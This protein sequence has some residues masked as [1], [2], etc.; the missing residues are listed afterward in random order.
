VLDINLTSQ[1]VASAQQITYG[2]SS[3]QAKIADVVFH[4]LTGPGYIVADYLCGENDAILSGKAKLTDIGLGD[5]KLV[6]KSLKGSMLV[7]NDVLGSGS[8]TATLDSKLTKDVGEGDTIADVVGSIQDGLED[9]WGAPVL[10]TT[11]PD[12]N[13]MT[14]AVLPYA[15][16]E[17]S[18]SMTAH[19]VID[20]ESPPVKYLFTNVTD[21]NKSSLWQDSATFTN[22]GLAEN[23]T[24][25]YNVQACDSATPTQNFTTIS[26][27]ANATTDQTADT[28]PPEPNVMTWAAGPNAISDSSIT[29]TA[30]TATDVHGVEYFF[31]NVTR[32][33]VNDVNHNGVGNAWQSSPTFTDTGLTANTNYKYNVK[34]RDKSTAQNPTAKSTPDA[35][36]MTF[37]DTN[38]PAPSPMTWAT[39]P[40][41]TGSSSITMKATTATDTS[42]PVQYEFWQ[43]TGT[44]AIVRAY[45]A[46]ANCTVTGLTEN[47]VYGYKVRAKDTL[48]NATAFSDSKSAQTGK[49]IQT[50]VTEAVAL[51]TANGTSTA[52]LTVPIAAGTYFGDIVVNDPNVT[53]QS[54]SGAA[55]TTIQLEAGVGIDLQAGADSFILDGFT[56]EPNFNGTT[57]AIQLSNAPTDVNIANNIIDTNATMGISIG[58]AGAVGLTIINNNITIKDGNGGIWGADVCDVSVLNNTIHGPATH[59]TSGYGIQFAGITGASLIHGN[60]LTNCGS[61]V[62]IQPHDAAGGSTTAKNVTISEN[63]I[64]QC[65]KGIRLGHTSAI[66]DMNDI[67]IY[68]N[69]L[70]QNLVGLYVDNNDAFIGMSTF[71]VYDN[72]FLDNSTFG[73]QNASTTLTLTAELNWWGGA[74][75]PYH[76][77]T[78]P[79][80]LGNDIVSDRVDYDPWYIT[81]AMDANSND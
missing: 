7:Y 3:Q 54:T 51:R 9:K 20:A 73:I 22:T 77:T 36:D 2:G 69:T 30:T 66:K 42:G 47:S 71:D 78:N 27:D 14:F 79:S 68:D 33:S 5:N 59:I 75:G 67:Y 34:A 43:T 21:S 40:T 49:T 38:A 39:E 35:N 72:S 8:M 52:R 10:D 32:D 48:G 19:T 12:P 50:Q 24:Y 57:F 37:V 4:S 46:D 13:A 16:S 61:G 70:Q 6:A 25:T 80:G 60:T 45:S 15:A 53:L 65:Q 11:P 1:V 41:A 74:L 17:T 81:S 56:I 44:T 31:T 23:T 62:F 58:A 28:T 76:A 64:T 29:M 18:I 55:A 63:I 26:A